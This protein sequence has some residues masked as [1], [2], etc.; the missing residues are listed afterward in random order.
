VQA[1]QAAFRWGRVAVA[2]PDA[3]R[4]A[5][6]APTSDRVLVA[7]EHLFATSSVAGAVRE[8][9]QRRAADLVAYQ[10]ERTAARLIDLIQRVWT[11][12]RTVT[13]RTDLAE[14]VTRNFFKL[15]AYKDEYEVARMLTEPNFLAS[16]RAQVSGGENL[17]FK[18]HP[19]MLK[20][21]GRKKKIG[22]G[23]RTHVVLRV[24]AR[25]KW[26]RGTP[27]DPFGYTHMRRAERLLVAHYE[28][29]IMDLLQSLTSESYERAVAVASAPDL[30]RGYEEVKIRNLATYSAR[31][32]ELGVDPPELPGLPPA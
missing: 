31:L 20:A 32:K 16:V 6:I 11:A 28:R 1:N 19:P 15:I 7:P 8:L 22:M 18:L 24:L 29:T 12:E 4:T 21:L 27:L 30:I 2:N 3:F 14:A 5:T 26:I 17:T 9:L 25:G 10:G 23:P 13:D